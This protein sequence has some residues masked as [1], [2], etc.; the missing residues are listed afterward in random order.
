MPCYAPSAM[1]RAAMLCTL[2]S[3]L[4]MQLQQS[5]SQSTRLGPVQWPRLP[6]AWQ[7]AH[8][9]QVASSVSLCGLVWCNRACSCVANHNVRVSPWLAVMRCPVYLAQAALCISKWPQVS[10]SVAW[11]GA[12]WLAP[13]LQ[14]F[15]QTSG[16]TAPSLPACQPARLCWTCAATLAALR[17]V[18]QQQAQQQ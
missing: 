13:V 16:R 9:N 10:H 14:G 12:T 17:S 8:S 18:Q 2:Y 3:I 1:P 6:A 4:N 11:C 15:T 5:C 7:P